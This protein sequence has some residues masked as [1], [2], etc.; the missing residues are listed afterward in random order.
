MIHINKIL[1]NIGYRIS[2]SSVFLYPCFG[3]ENPRLFDYVDINDDTIGSF[4]AD[5][6]G[7]VFEIV[8]EIPQIGVCYRWIDPEFR[9]QIIKDAIN[10]GENPSHAWD[11]VTY[12]DIEDEESMVVKIHAIANKIYFDTSGLWPAEIS[13]PN[14]L[15]IAKMAAE[16]NIT[17]NQMI[18]ILIKK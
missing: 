13:D 7:R 10:R 8:A 4:T 9:D 6:T 17:F 3:M 12:T 11:D 14:F 1:E 18:E 5:E 15:K 16:K 2:Q